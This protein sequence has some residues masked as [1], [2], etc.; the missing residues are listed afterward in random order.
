MQTRAVSASK[1]RNILNSSMAESREDKTNKRIKRE[2][3]REKVVSLVGGI[4]T[5]EAVVTG[6]R[7]NC[8]RH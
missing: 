6:T 3:E 1:I 7:N 2:R 8:R 5:T 4:K